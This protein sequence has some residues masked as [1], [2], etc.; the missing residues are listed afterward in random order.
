MK[1]LI[2]LFTLIILT[3]PVLAQCPTGENCSKCMDLTTSMY[4][5]RATMFNVLNLS[6]DQQKCKDTMDTHYL[7]EVG[8]KFEKYE[9]EKVVKNC[10]KSLL[11][12][13]F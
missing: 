11:N 8:D 3:N 6:A 4:D 13:I 1:N 9:Q 7:Q 2:L 12:W 10:Q 5:K